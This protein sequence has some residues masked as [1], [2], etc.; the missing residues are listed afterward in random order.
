MK[1]SNLR[2]S[3]AGTQ[4]SASNS[5][6]PVPS[7]ISQAMVQ[8]R[9]EA[10]K[11]RIAPAPDSP[12]T[13]RDHV[14]S[15]PQPSGVRSPIPVTTTRLDTRSSQKTSRARQ[16]REQYPNRGGR[17]LRPGRV[18]T[19]PDPARNAKRRP[20]RAPS[21]RPPRA[22]VPPR[23]PPWS[24]SPRPARRGSA[25]GVLGDELHRVA[26]GLDG[27]GGVV[28]DLDAELLLERHHQL[29]G[30]ERVRAEIVDEAGALDHLVLLDGQVLHHDLLH[31]L[32]NV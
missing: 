31:A 10:S 25:L 6:S 21:S 16:G 26:E 23:A 24:R 12:A 27:L 8:G 29:D 28:R 9:C 14:A 3:L 17:Y 5:P 13:S 30:V 32:R 15:T 2:R 18:A 11:C 7:G 22:A 20:S 1:R 19:A 4:A